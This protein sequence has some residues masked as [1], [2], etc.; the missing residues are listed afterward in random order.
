MK[1]LKTKFEMDKLIQEAKES[2]ASAKEWKK[3]Q[4]Q[5]DD[6][7]SGAS[8]MVSGKERLADVNK[9][10]RKSFENM[11]KSATKAIQRN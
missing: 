3:I 5:I 7:M 11:K 4:D 9:S 6:F 10:M 8:R 2:D 1:Q